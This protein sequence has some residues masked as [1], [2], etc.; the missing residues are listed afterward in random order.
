MTPR[1]LTGGRWCGPVPTGDGA[2]CIDTADPERIA[3]TLT[4]ATDPPLPNNTVYKI[5]SDADRR[6]Y[7]FTNKGVARLTPATRNNGQVGP[8]FDVFT[9][10]V[11]DGLPL[12][13]CNRNAGMVDRLG[14]IWVGT[15]GG[16]AVFDP[17][18][19]ARDYLPSRSWSGNARPGE[20]SSRRL[21][22]AP[23]LAF[24][25]NDIDFE[26]ALLSFFRQEDTR[27]RAQLVGFDPQ[28]S[29]WSAD[30]KE[31]RRLPDGNLC[32]GCGAH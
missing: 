20:G 3:L 6:L 29:M 2:F 30:F 19:E 31:Y 8:V 5:L 17:G 12:N 1:C 7:M 28:P 18:T 16:A 15:V 4:D 26:Y 13:Q 23:R 14:R 32:S 27:Y 24:N 21:R 10:T 25:E 11:E 22:A 9:F